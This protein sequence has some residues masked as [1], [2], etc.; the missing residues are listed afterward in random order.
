MELK[1]I[2]K[3]FGNDEL[4]KVLSDVSLKI[5]PGSFVCLIGPNGCGKSTLLKIIAGLEKNTSG[6]LTRPRKIAYLPQQDSLMPWLS[7]RENLCLPALIKSISV[8]ELDNKIDFYL[9]KFNLSHFKNFY[10]HQLS[11][12]TKQKVALLRAVLYEPE[13]ILLDEPFSSVD[14]ITRNQIQDWLE[15]LWLEKRPIIICV[16]HDIHEAIR[17]AD[18]VVVLSKR[19]AKI[20]KKFDLDATRPRKTSDSNYSKTYDQLKGIL[21]NEAL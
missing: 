6:E 7:V 16:T 13:L 19:P 14:S 17:L 21:Q 8:T 12:G 11:G 20:I 4:T 3:N 15:N 1:S 2:T 10:P 9:D 18:Q 5:K